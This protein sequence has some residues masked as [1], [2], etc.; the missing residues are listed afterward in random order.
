[1]DKPTG[2]RSGTLEIYKETNEGLALQTLQKSNSAILD[3]KFD[4]FDDELIYVAGSTGDF[5]IWRFTNDD[6]TFVAKF[7]LFDQNVLVTSLTP[8]H[9]LHNKILLTTTDGYLSLLTLNK[10]SHGVISQQLDNFETPYDLQS[11]I[12]ALGNFNVLANIVFSVGYDAILI[13]YDMR[14]MMPAFHAKRHHEPGDVAIRIVS[15]VNHHGNGDWSMDKP[16]RLLTGSYDDCIRDLDLRYVPDMGLIEGIPPRLNEK[17]NLGGGVWKQEPCVTPGDNR[18]AVCCMYDGAR[19]IDPENG[20]GVQRY[21][22]K[23]HE[24]MVYGCDWSLD[25]GKIASCSFYDNV[26]QIWSTTKVED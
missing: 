21:F 3:L 11:G 8:S 5:Q 13:V 7:Q 1:M 9:V 18:L 25:G 26:I 4:A 2:T 17:L 16:Y 20:F 12:S 23:E 6:L 22:K 15:R 19:I 10:D 14:S 24:S